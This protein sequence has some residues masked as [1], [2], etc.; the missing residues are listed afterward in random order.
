MDNTQAIETLSA[1]AQETRM[2]IFRLLVRE[3]PSGLNVGEISKRLDIVP[4][5]LSG[6]LSILKHGNLVRSERSKTQII[7]SA[8]LETL[9]G[10]VH[11]LI[12]DCCDGRV[13]DCGDL[14]DILAHTTIR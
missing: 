4:S 10:L 12:A 13:E 1:L 5:T 14:L 8:N 7:Y 11:F 9:G 2:E 6:H 3:E